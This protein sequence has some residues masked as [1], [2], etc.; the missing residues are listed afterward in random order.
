MKVLVTGGTSLIGRHTVDALR[1]VGH[2]VITLQRG[3]DSR[4]SSVHGSITDRDAVAT[5]CTGQEAV[6]HLAA[7]VGVTGARDEYERTN[8]DGTELMIQTA[9]DCGVRRFVHV[10]SPSVAHSGEPLI[11]AGAT[12]ADPTRTRGHYATTKANA[13]LIALDASSTE[14]PIVAIRPHLVWGPGDT[15]LVERIVDRARHGRLAVVGSG[16]ALID[17]TYVTNAA[18]ALVAALDHAH[19]IGGRA[20]V[21]SNGEPRTVRELFVRIA[22]AA[23]VSVRPRR[24]PVRAAVLGGS[25][26]ERV[27]E[28]TGRLDDPPMTS[29]LAEQLST[30]HWFEQQTTR[31]AL[32]WAPTVTLDEGFQRLRE[33]FGTSG[34]RS[35]T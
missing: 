33:A 28:R 4:G 12:P 23:G 16:A 11:G 3:D 29:F 30:A 34:S 21:V 19:E 31:R 27:W 7:K 1:R 17:T 8:V 24:V 35:S 13:E 5:A 15:Q 18:E 9:R 14:M 25:F 6:V 20:F 10:S 32:R 2:D 26:V 22:A